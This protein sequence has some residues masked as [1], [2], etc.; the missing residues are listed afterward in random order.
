MNY[1]SQDRII[2]TIISILETL[3]VYEENIMDN[4]STQI[5]ILLGHHNLKI[6]KDVKV[7]IIKTLNLLMKFNHKK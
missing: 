1:E 3:L 6:R 5:P 4:I 2:I 7:L